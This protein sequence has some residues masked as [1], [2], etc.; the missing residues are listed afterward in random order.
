M[1][2]ADCKVESPLTRF[3]STRISIYGY[4][5]ETLRSHVWFH[6]NP[7]TASDISR[8]W[9]MQL[10]TISRALGSY[11]SGITDSGSWFEI[12]IFSPKNQG[13]SQLASPSEMPSSITEVHPEFTILGGV[14]FAIK[15]RADGE[16][17]TWI[18]HN[19]SGGER[20]ATRYD[21]L[22]YGSRHELWS[23]LSPGD[24]IAVLACCKD[25]RL[26]TGE[27]ALLKF[28]EHFDLRTSQNVQ[29]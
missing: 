25:G 4:S 3:I 26:C 21:G 1:R 14:D 2:L 28:W 27:R 18:S 13:Q 11:N 5:N 19:N 6:T 23:Y 10:T 12:A 16:A 24:C 17:L 22:V 29:S 8:I 9:G 20:E 15:Y 7:L